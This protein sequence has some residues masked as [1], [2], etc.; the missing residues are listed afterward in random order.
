MLPLSLLKTFQGHPMCYCMSIRVKFRYGVFGGVNVV[1]F[2]YS[3]LQ[4]CDLVYQLATGGDGTRRHYLR[5]K[6]Q[7]ATKLLLSKGVW[8]S[9]EREK[10]SRL[11]GQAE[12]EQEISEQVN[13]LFVSSSAS[14]V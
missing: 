3:V 9:P 10:A 14:V 2:A 1:G 4:G 5:Y 12:C 13:I 7:G 11:G 8:D 6:R